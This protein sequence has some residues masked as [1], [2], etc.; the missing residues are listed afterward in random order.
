[1]RSDEFESFTEVIADLCAAYDRTPSDARNRSFWDVLKGFHLHDVK[2]SALKWR[3]TQRKMPSP[4]DLKPERA[5]APPPKPQDD[6]PAMSRWAA[7]ANKLLLHVA[8]RDPRRGF[9]PIAKYEP[10]PAGGYRLPLVWTQAKCRDDSLLK[11]CLEIKRDYVQM[12]EQAELSGEPMDG[13]EFQAM[14]KEGF[15]KAL[16]IRV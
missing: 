8:Y 6:D 10:A 13:Q 14:C 7:A 4:A 3:N 16:G 11:R 9:V 1:M 12:A 15:E 5:S 2:R